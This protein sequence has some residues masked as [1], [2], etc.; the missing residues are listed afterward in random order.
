MSQTNTEE[1]TICLIE[2]RP[3]PSD[4]SVSVVEAVGDPT[5]VYSSRIQIDLFPLFTKMISFLSLEAR[6][7]SLKLHTTPSWLAGNH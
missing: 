5:K 7:S 3:S 2:I 1:T 4:L 6:S